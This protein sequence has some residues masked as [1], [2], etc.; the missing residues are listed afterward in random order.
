MKRRIAL[1]LAGCLAL[2]PVSA[3]FPSYQVKA[4]ETDAASDLLIEISVVVKVMNDEETVLDTEEALELNTGDSYQI[5]A[6]YDQ[7]SAS[8]SIS[9]VWNSVTPD[10]VTIDDNG[11]L[12]AISPGTGQI[13]L[14]LT[15]GVDEISY[16]YVIDV[17]EPE[18][19]ED[20]EKEELEEIKEIDSEAPAEDAVGADKMTDSAAPEDAARE[21]RLRDL[22]YGTCRSGNR[23][24]AD[25]PAC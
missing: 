8:G 6:E 20:Q 17:S 14:D 18:E 12:E 13:E 24:I 5:T 21:L 19:Q 16:I 2:S 4:A 25:R 7:N 9:H 3:G 15:D 22:R 11:V 23:Y 1:L 10:I